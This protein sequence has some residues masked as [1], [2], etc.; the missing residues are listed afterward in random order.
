MYA[1]PAWNSPT[2][3]M[4][5]E[6]M[7]NRSRSLPAGVVTD[8]ACHRRVVELQR[9]SLRG[10]AVARVCARMTEPLSGKTSNEAVVPDRIAKP[11]ASR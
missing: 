6:R 10:A 3:H 1:L 4:L 11:L 8:N 2:P 9:S 5:P 7:M